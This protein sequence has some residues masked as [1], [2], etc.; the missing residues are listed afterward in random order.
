MRVVYAM[1]DTNAW[2][3]F[4]KGE[5]LPFED[6]SY[7]RL[8]PKAGS[9]HIEDYLRKF[10]ALR[11]WIVNKD[12]WISAKPAH[13]LCEREFRLS[14]DI[15]A[16]M[17]NNLGLTSI[18]GLFFSCSLEPF[19]GARKQVGEA[20]LRSFARPPRVKLGETS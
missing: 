3:F 10:G 7:L 8:A 17:S 20:P 12:F 14:G 15:A 5:P 4:E 1:R 19:P 9:P 11:L 13:L 18:R 16:E 6:L 2:D